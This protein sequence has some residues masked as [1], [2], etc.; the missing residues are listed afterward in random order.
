[1]KLLTH[2]LLQ[3]PLSGTYPLKI[4]PREVERTETEYRHDVRP[5]LTPPPRSE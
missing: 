3:C 5:P 2:N 1:M 4:V